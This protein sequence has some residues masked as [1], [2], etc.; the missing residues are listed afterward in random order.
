MRETANRIR[1]VWLDVILTQYVSFLRDIFPA[2]PS[3]LNFWT[4]LDLA[5]YSL[6][7]FIAARKGAQQ[8]GIYRDGPAANQAFYAR[9][10]LANSVSNLTFA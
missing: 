4:C 8:V 3:L 2:A 10:K 7:L 1:L 9:F 5:V 6:A